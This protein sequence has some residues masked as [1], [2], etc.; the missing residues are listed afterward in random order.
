M[1]LFM[2]T[3]NPHKKREM[4][5]LL[6]D[7]TLFIPSDKNIDFT[8]EENGKSFYENSFLK[9]KTLWDIVQHP[10]LADDSGLCIDA[11][12]GIPGIYSARYAGMHYPQGTRDNHSTSQ[13]E[14]NNML[15]EHTTHILHKKYGKKLP[16]MS[17]KERMA[18][19]SCYYVCAMTLYL[20]KD[21]FYCVQKVFKGQLVEHINEQ[22]GSNGF[23]YDPIVYLPEYDK[24]VAEIPEAEK[25][26]ISH[27][28]KATNKILTLI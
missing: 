17:K 16:T 3:N 11:L 1:T 2:A 5:K 4:A 28:A 8:A 22:R 14:Q 24:T 25:N 18:L 7:H 23:G 21:S 6:K 19:R 9:A 12:D 26:T 13:S 20:E 10:V 15:I 27:R